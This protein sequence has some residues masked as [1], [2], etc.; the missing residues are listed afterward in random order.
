MYTD[1]SGSCLYHLFQWLLS[2]GICFVIHG[3]LDSVILGH[4]VQFFSVSVLQLKSFFM[5]DIFYFLVVQFTNFS[6]FFDS[7]LM[8]FLLII[9][10]FGDM[11]EA[12]APVSI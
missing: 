7:T 8:G 2:V 5:S 4:F 3:I 11:F 1:I 6:I 9:I 10:T 12:T